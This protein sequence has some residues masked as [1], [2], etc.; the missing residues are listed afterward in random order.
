MHGRAA[1]L[2]ATHHV[3]KI[4]KRQ[5][6]MQPAHHVKFRGTLA[7]TLFG[8][9][10]DLVQRESISTR[11]IRIASKRAQLAMRHADVG[12][13]DVPVHIEEA[14]VAMALLAHRIGEPADRK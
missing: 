6:G 7:H 13:I 10:P 5:V 8:A 1:L 14:C 11:R 9:L 3:Q 12:G 2:Q 4:F